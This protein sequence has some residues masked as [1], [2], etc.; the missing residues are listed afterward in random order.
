MFYNKEKF[1]SG[2][3][4]FNYDIF[5]VNNGFTKEELVNSK[6]VAAMFLLDQKITPQEF[7]DDEIIAIKTDL[8]LEE[9]KSLRK[10]S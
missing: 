3:L 10:N 6:N 5:D 7:L 1:D 8:N 4:N 9:I 2:V